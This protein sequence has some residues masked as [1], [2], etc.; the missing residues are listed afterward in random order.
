[1]TDPALKEEEEQSN[2]ASGPK[3]LA[4]HRMPLPAT[5]KFTCYGMLFDAGI[6]RDPKGG[7]Q[8]V[9]RG[10]LGRLPYSAESA[11][12]RNYL[13]TVI[14]AGRSLPNAEIDVDR[15]QAI[16]VRGKMKFP[17]VP[18]PATVAAGTAAIAIAIRPVCELVAKCRR[19]GR[20]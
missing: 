1:L 9:V 4:S 11:M 17:M 19:A 20:V 13:H 5:F 14:D 2:A 3:V 15:K 16:I 12:A 8:L 7:A 6:A 18:S 10:D